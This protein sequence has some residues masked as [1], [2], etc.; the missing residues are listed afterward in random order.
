MKIDITKLKYYDE[1]A[2]NCPYCG[3]PSSNCDGN[4]SYGYICADCGNEFETPDT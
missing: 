4:G 3:C 2:Y 1:S